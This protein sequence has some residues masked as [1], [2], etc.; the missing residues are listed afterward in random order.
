MFKLLH[1]YSANIAVLTH[2]VEI[3]R[4][5]YLVCYLDYISVLRTIYVF[6]IK[7]YTDIIHPPPLN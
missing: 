3:A 1:P 7:R 5:I 6:K 2:I 4:N